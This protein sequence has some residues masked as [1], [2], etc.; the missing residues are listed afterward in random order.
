MSLGTNSNEP[1]EFTR[2][3]TTH[4]H[5]QKQIQ[6]HTA[7]DFSPAQRLA[8]YKCLSVSNTYTPHIYTH[9]RIHSHHHARAQSQK[10]TRAQQWAPALLKDLQAVIVEVSGTVCVSLYIYMRL[11]LSVSIYTGVRVHTYIYIYIYIYWRNHCI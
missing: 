8:H 10:H 3:H 6:T 5:T 11:S 7:G 4:T 1:F 2:V 9:M